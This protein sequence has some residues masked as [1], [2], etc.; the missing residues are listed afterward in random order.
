MRRSSARR[1]TSPRSRQERAAIATAHLR[2]RARRSPLTDKGFSIAHTCY[3]Q[4]G[5]V[6][7]AKTTIT[8]SHAQLV[9]AHPCPFQPGRDAAAQLVDAI[10]AG[11]V[12]WSI[13]GGVLT[14]THDGKG[15]LVWSDAVDQSGGTPLDGTDWQL[16][17]A[18]DQDGVE[19]PAAGQSLRINTGK[20]QASDG[21]NTI[22]GPVT[23]HDSVLT[24]GELATSAVGSTQDDPVRDLIDAVISGKVSYAIT[25]DQLVLSKGSEQLIYRVHRENSTHSIIGTWSLTTIEHGTGP[26]GTASPPSTPIT[27]TFGANRI[28]VA[29][30]CL[31]RVGRLSVDG[32]ALAIGDLAFVADLCHYPELG[33]DESKTSTVSC[34]RAPGRSTATS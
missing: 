7:V 22:S 19:H 28:T 21:T 27:F 16:E 33:T 25:G 9:D 5:D 15:K 24:F 2:P 10:V 8:I 20:V 14:I 31:Q 29:G 26:D 6:D 17:T 1:G 12:T 11:T 32:D 18:V 34:T 4:Q 23:E 30:D 3:T 13:D